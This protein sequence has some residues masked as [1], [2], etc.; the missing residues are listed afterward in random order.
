ME[1]R[2]AIIWQFLY[3]VST[4]QDGGRAELLT[5]LGVPFERFIDLA[6]QP[7]NTLSDGNEQAMIARLD[8]RTDH[9][10]SLPWATKHY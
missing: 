9:R 7:P 10:R 5:G 6:K 4:T 3:A 1:W 8:S 2:R